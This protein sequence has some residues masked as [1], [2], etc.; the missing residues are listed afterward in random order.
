MQKTILTILS[1]VI[2]STSFTAKGQTVDG[3]VKKHIAAIGGA[4]NW[5]KIKTIKTTGSFISSEGSE[6]IYS[7][8]ISD[9]VG[10][11]KEFTYPSTGMTA[12]IIVTPT[13]GWSFIPIT[14]MKTSAKAVP[15]DVLER[16]QYQLR[17]Q[18]PLLDYKSKGNTVTL[19]GKEKVK[20]ADC[21]K[22][23]VTDKKGA[24]EF[25][26]IDAVNYY[27]IRTT[28]MNTEHGVE[29]EEEVKA[30]GEFKKLPEG[31]VYPMLL[32]EGIGA[33]R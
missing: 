25:V 5:K 15:Q 23:K 12:F 28:H 10:V 6:V 13:V 24:F 19:V 11:R 32:D 3:I 26:F 30:Y 4:E 29:S 7:S 9:N 16:A 14:G 8:I 33:I 21:F 31:I 27:H 20:D 2:L 17:I 22:L 18:S 1:F